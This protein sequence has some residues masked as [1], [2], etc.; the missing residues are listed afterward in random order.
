MLESWIGEIQVGAIEIIEIPEDYLKTADSGDR[1]ANYRQSFKS[2]LRGMIHAKV[3]IGLRLERIDGRT[4]VFILTWS[5]KQEELSKNLTT[6]TASVSA[7]L[8]KFLISQVK[9]FKGL[10]IG[11]EIS[12]VTACL[13]GEPKGLE[14]SGEQAIQ[15]DPMDA[16]GEILQSLDNVIL[17]INVEPTK[18]GKGHVRTLERAFENAME[19]SQKVVSGP[20]N[21]SRGSQQ[22]TTIVNASASREAERLSRQVKRMSSRYLGKVSVTVTH[23]NQ[24]RKV[25]TTQA[26]RVM[27]VLMSGVTPA[28]K[29]E[30]FRVT[31][32]KKRKDFENALAGKPVG[33]YTVLTPDEAAIYFSLPRVDIGIKV[34][35]REDFSVASVDVE[36]NMKVEEVSPR[37]ET[38]HE[39]STMKNMLLEREHWSNPNSQSVWRFPQKKLIQLGLTIRNGRPQQYQPY[40]LVPKMLGSHVAIYGNTGY[41]KTTTC[42]SLVAQTYRNDV[43]P[44]ILTPGNVGDWRV[45]KDLY[46]EFRIFTAGNPDVAPLHY[47]MWNVPPKVPVGKYIDRMVDVHVAALPTDGVISMHFD[48]IFNTMYENCGWSRMGNIRGR[49]ILLSDLFQAFQQVAQTHLEYGED[50]KKDFYGAL[51]ARLRSV[52][53]NEI[54][55]DMF[56]T[57]TGLTIPDLLSKPTII[58]MRDLSPEDRALLIGALTVGIS[59][60]LI[61]NP[62]KEVRHV[63]VLE[64]AHQFLKGTQNQ[65]AYAEPTSTQKAISN[66]CEMMRIQRG[67]GLGF[68]II[69][70][71]VS[72]LPPEIVKLPSNIII[73]SLTDL[74]ERM[75]AGRQALCSDAQISHIGG[76]GIGE[77]VARIQTQTVPANVQIAPLN[78]LL[79]RPL[80]K[81]EWTDEMVRD[82]MRKEFSSHPELAESLALTSEMKNLLRGIRSSSRLPV[83]PEMQVIQISRRHEVDISEIVNVPLF[84]DE[85]K[86]R[87]V[88]ASIGNPGP[89]ARL[90]N[91][92]ARKFCA[93][94]FE[95]VPFAE[96]LLLHAAGML[97]EPKETAVLAD[98]LVAIRGVDA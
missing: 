77:V 34:S 30:D 36:E 8:P 27:S 90:L 28:D 29:E 67:T 5:K 55:V 66:I 58:E 53:R 60:Y 25:A 61:A 18:S 96:R 33:D 63:L 40:G 68:I 59:E 39:S 78:Y 79:T 2:I 11:S 21:S 50:L 13:L 82:A 15:I 76:M 80:P 20:R 6:L 88:S 4:R 7:Y 1:G 97:Q 10:K 69:D 14:D 26:K 83:Q 86:K 16:A 98:I 42:V 37:P 70:Q 93:E 56:N 92:V 74:E 45:L 87:V 84:I 52:L 38:K 72:S 65:G 43:I 48:D 95:R 89:V 17:Q 49:P 19:R 35:R 46:P 54:L 75:L 85:Y 22:S 41:G 23:W 71:L 12:G 44:I 57:T 3:P 32:K 9:E 51:D 31:I 94:D 81:R 47:N 62:K 24:D 64:E 73:H 91:S